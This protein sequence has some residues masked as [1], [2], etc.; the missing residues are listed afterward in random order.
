MAIN[1]YKRQVR[2][3]PFFFSGFLLSHTLHNIPSEYRDHRSL[4][5][6]LIFTKYKFAFHIQLTL[7]I[8]NNSKAQNNMQP[9]N[10]G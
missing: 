9:F 4:G 7:L 2:L 5:N 3:S 1:D 8:K 6:G 10:L